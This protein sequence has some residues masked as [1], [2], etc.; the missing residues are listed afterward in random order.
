MNGDSECSYYSCLPADLLAQA[1]QL[2][3]KV[4]S[5]LALMLHS[6]K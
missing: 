5:H 1:D 3:S 2:G 6:V 4:G